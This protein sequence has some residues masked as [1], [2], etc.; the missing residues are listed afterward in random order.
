[1]VYAAQMPRRRRANASQVRQQIRQSEEARRTHVDALVGSDV[2]IQ[3]SFVTLG[4]RCGKPNCRCAAGDKHLS[5]YVSRSEGGK[6]RVIYVPAGDEVDVAQKT[7]RYRR[8]REARAELLKL[9][10]Q[11]SELA[12][13]LQEVLAEPYPPP[14]R[15]RGRRR[16]GK[17]R[18][19]Q[20]R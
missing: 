17:A 20:S 9:A 14:N 8:L 3:G 19:G 15:A 13:E 2:L 16:K 18:G 11:T 5:K 12:D 1:M 6:T 4:R 10:A 7:E